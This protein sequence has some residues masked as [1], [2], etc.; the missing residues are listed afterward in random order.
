MTYGPK[1]RL[2]AHDDVLP[3]VPYYSSPRWLFLLSEISWYI[4]IKSMR[5]LKLPRSQT[6][7]RANAL[8]Q[9]LCDASWRL[10]RI[11]MI[12]IRQRKDGNCLC[13]VTLR[14][15]IQ[16]WARIAYSYS[17]TDDWTL[18]VMLLSP[19]MR[20]VVK[21]WTYKRHFQ[22]LESLI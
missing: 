9:P 7:L 15:L 2:V 18:V 6:E 17:N 19:A 8:H 10:Y 11:R 22:S 21:S 20:K 1:N 13:F 3:F 16:T 5:F 14:P 12:G 4:Q